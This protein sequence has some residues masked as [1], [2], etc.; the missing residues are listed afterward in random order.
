M[1][2][3]LIGVPFDGMGRSPGQA[4]APAALRAAGLEA[5]LSSREVVSSPDLAL[6]AARAERADDSGLLNGVALLTM[7]Q[8]LE[9][10]LRASMSVGHVPLVYGADCSVLLG[11]LP[12][13]RDTMGEP[14]LLFID[15]HEDATP[16]EQS[17]DGEAANMEIAILLGMTGGRLPPPLRTS[18]G[19][20]KPDALVMLGPR[21]EAWRHPIGVGTVAGR[22]S[23]RGA[24]EVSA[25]PV[26]VAREAV[27]YLASRV[28]G[29]WLHTDLDVLDRR[30]FSACG[31]AGEVALSGGLTWPQLTDVVRAALDAGECRGWSLV[32]YDPDLDPDGHQARRIVQFVSD[33]APHLPH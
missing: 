15:G 20:L 7:I 28:H 11:A 29:W 24:E 23:L 21:D 19:V 5:A 22:V 4:G 32:I 30:D 17:P 3:D 27:R 13:L 16:M 18:F 26:R 8:Q 10:A 12:A 6:P 14:G 1:V 9:A 33:V 25:Q 2:V 31:A